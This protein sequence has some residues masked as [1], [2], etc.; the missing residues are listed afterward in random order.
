VSFLKDP[1]PAGLIPANIA[2]AGGERIVGIQADSVAYD[3]DVLVIH[4]T[5]YGDFSPY[6]L[7]LVEP[8]GTGNPLSGLDPLLSEI[9]FRFKAECPSDLDCRT[10]AAC[11]PPP[12]TMPQIDY[13][14]KD[15][16]GF[17]RLM[18]DRM[19]LTAPGWTERNPADLGVA[20]V[21]ILAYAGDH[22]SYRQDAVATEAYLG[23]AR[24]RISLR[25]HARLVDYAIHDGCNARV[26]VAL[27]VD[28]I[29]DGLVL[30]GPR[31][32]LLPL[33]A[34]GTLL[35]TRV[36][37]AAVIAPASRALDRA[38]AAAPT[39]FETMHDLILF[40]QL[41]QLHFYSWGDAECCLP[42]GSL[43]ATLVGPLPDLAGRLVI[44]QEMVSPTTGRA[45]D[46]DPTHRHAV[47]IVTATAGTDPV[48]GTAIVEIA[49]G[50]ADAL[51]FSLCVSSVTDAAHGALVIP[52]VGLGWGNVVL[53]DH[54]RTLDPEDLGSVPAPTLYYAPA[55]GGD[56]CLAVAP[57]PVMPRFRP[58]LGQG[59]VTQAAFVRET[60]LF[61]GQPESVALSFDPTA[62]ARA[63]LQWDEGDCLPA[64]W[65]KSGGPDDTV[66]TVRG[67]LLESNETSADFVAETDSDGSTTIRFG[68]DEYG[69]RPAT[70]DRFTAIYRIG[71]GVAGN[72]GAGTIAHVV[73]ALPGITGAVNP[74]AAGGGQDPEAEDSIRM[75]APE[76]FRIQER[77]VTAA[78]YESVSLRDPDVAKAAATFRWTGSWHTVFDTVD[79]TGGAVVD[80]PF[81]TGLRAFLERYRVVGHD[82]EV[83]APIFVPL[84]LDLAVCVRA[85]WFR[86]DI[87]R[88]LRALLGSGSLSDGR[89]GF[90]NRSRHNFGETLYLS[91]LYALAQSVPGVESVEITRFERL[92]QPSPD[93]LDNWQLAFGDLEIPR[94][95]SDPDFPE[96]GLVN[97]TVR[98][99]Q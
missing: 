77:A 92:Y 20:L 32:G 85:P 53:A 74:I 43:S 56:R 34:P 2:I 95:D 17:R 96:H 51:P 30:P 21:E 50:A 99:G 63:T 91:P 33:P 10:D 23:T 29:A 64:I 38:L 1:P 93:G 45:G 7:R 61:E 78:D 40:S 84:R 22:L 80:D 13:L 46:A 81:R 73:T 15:Y 37:E 59:P 28:P 49:W 39:A 16:A 58:V 52:E 3:G 54:G 87:E 79:R 66:W 8:D 9:R 48:T 70:G 57:D 11:V 82:L 83:T 76:A 18:L 5:A 42:K 26:L 44:F 86:A 98:G 41:S 35:L 55:G 72:V 94:C 24:R 65:L 27:T 68:D 62:P 89:P 97:L 90:F 75:A 25:R 4:L 60:I 69:I 47:R 36:A 88:E 71:N 31:P 12:A 6:L 19:A 67:D 14:A